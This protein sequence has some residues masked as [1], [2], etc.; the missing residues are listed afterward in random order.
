MKF[1][2]VDNIRWMQ[3]V[4]AALHKSKLNIARLPTQ[5]RTPV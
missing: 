4:N 3:L 2:L 5:S 1:I